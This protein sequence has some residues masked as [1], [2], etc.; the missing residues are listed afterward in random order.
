M[1]LL[2]LNSVLFCFEKTRFPVNYCSY[3]WN[4][5]LAMILPQREVAENRVTDELP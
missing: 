3:L 1:Q 5:I 2:G 4:V